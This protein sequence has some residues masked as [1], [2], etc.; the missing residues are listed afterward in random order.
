[1]TATFLKINPLTIT[2]IWG[3]QPAVNARYDFATSSICELQF[4]GILHQDHTLS[5]PPKSL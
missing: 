3:D 4:L 1:M 2:T 5:N